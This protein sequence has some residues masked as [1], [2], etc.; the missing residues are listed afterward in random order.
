MNSISVIIQAWAPSLYFTGQRDSGG[1]FDVGGFEVADSR[2]P[3]VVN[4]NS[5]TGMKPGEALLGHTPL[6][7]QVATMC[8][9]I[10]GIEPPFE[11]T[12]LSNMYSRSRAR[13]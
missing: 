11:A 4:H 3:R 13:Y 5:S 6:V 8:A 9:F 2:Y 1:R 12:T 7:I 10:R